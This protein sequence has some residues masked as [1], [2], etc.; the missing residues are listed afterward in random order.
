MN[1]IVANPFGTP[2][3]TPGSGMA[4]A[5][6]VSSRENTEVLALVTSAKRFP[7]DPMKAA[8]LIREDFM[9]PTLAEVAQYQF[10]RGGTDIVGPSIRSAEAISQRWGNMATGWS[11]LE[12]GPGPDGVGVS[13]V[14]AFAV[15]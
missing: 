10:A 8:N 1:D 12:R 2:A 5:V 3:A 15:D 11:E 6:A 4:A 14:E 9:R 13:T 7:R